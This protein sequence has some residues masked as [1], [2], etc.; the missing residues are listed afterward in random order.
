MNLITAAHIRAAR[1]LLGWSAEELA[2]RAKIGVATVRRAE[3]TTGAL[4]I[5]EAN[6]DAIVR[7][8]ESAG[9]EFPDA[10]QGDVVVRLRGS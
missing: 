4:K 3:S 6:Q 10:A 9:I 5:T 7:A 2:K 8:F 1:A